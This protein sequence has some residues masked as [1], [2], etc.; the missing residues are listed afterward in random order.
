MATFFT[1]MDTY[2]ALNPDG[3]DVGNEQDWQNIT[4]TATFTPSV[5]ETVLDIGAGVTSTVR[6]EPIIGR[7]NEDGV[8]STLDGT[9]GVGLLCGSDDETSNLHGLTYKVEFSNV[10]FNRRRDQR[11]EPFRFKAPTAQTIIR[12]SDKS[13]T[14]RVQ[15]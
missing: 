1:V 11:I 2:R 7:F 4:G 6:L 3:P 9:P 15:L 12:L 8:L 13:Q 10:V 5:A 14:E